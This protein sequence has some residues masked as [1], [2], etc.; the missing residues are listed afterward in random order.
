MNESVVLPIIGYMRSPYVEK[1]GIPR[2]PNLVDVHSQI[3]LV[4]PYN[5]PLAFTGIEQF[6]HLWLLWYF[7]DNKDTAQTKSIFRPLIR[8]PR[9]GGNQKIGVFAS[10]SMYRPAAIG[11]SVV[12]FVG[13]EQQGGQWLLRVSGADLLN[14]T[15]IFDIKPYIA[16]SDS[17]P[18][19]MSGYAQ[20]QPRQN[21]VLWTADAVCAQQQLLAQG[22]TTAQLLNELNQ[23]LSLDPR[24]AYQHDATREYGLHFA[25]LNVRFRVSDGTVIV[26][27]I[28]VQ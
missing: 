23:V 25:M 8:P 21:E 18:T 27:S 10:R 12:R 11:L 22:Q 14:G 28:T 5:N 16:Y 9:L 15:P 19:A 26:D 13:F 4:S 6:S 7:H 17:I 24:P 1:F 20:E 3:E 2:Q